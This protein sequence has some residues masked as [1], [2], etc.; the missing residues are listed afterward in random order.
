MERSFTLTETRRTT[1]ADGARIV[2]VI[3]TRD[4]NTFT[5]SYWTPRADERGMW[6]GYYDESPTESW[7]GDLARENALTW[8][9]DV[10]A[11]RPNG[12]TL[13]APAYG[14]PFIRPTGASPDSTW[15]PTHA[16]WS[17]QCAGCRNDARDRA[18]AERHERAMAFVD[19]ISNGA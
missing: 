1:V 17:V 12:R 13:G 5:A 9:G 15:C 10:Y 14:V 8:L 4:G 18:D 19:G 3:E 11:H 7:N 16:V 2:G 6:C